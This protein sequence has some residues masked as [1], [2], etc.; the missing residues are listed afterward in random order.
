MA[1]A[2]GSE[3]NCVCVHAQVGVGWAE[4]VTAL[5]ELEASWQEWQPPPPLA[6]QSPRLSGMRQ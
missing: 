6:A 5:V 1:E 2:L 4:P 3:Q